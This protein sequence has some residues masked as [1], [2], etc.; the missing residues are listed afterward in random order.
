VWGNGGIASSILDFGTFAS[1]ALIFTLS[2]RT[3]C[4]DFACTIE[5]AETSRS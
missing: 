1:Q 2:R 4:L 5:D 3:G